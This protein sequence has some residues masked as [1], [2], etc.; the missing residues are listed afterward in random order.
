METQLLS[1]F[2]SPGDLDGWRSFYRRLPLFS[3]P[4]TVPQPAVQ[5]FGVPVAQTYSRTSFQRNLHVTEENVEGLAANVGLSSRKM[6]PWN[7]RVSSWQ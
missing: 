2:P 1:Y 6:G 4:R 3:P 5:L 7:P